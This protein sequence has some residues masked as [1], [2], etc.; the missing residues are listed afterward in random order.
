MVQETAS[1]AA[2]VPTDPVAIC[3]RRDLASTF[4]ITLC[5]KRVLELEKEGRFPRNVP[6]GG[7]AAYRVSDI[8]QWIA[9]RFAQPQQ[10]RQ[11]PPPESRT[12][13]GT[14]GANIKRRS[15]QP[16]ART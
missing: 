2:C 7:Q 14:A 6:I 11:V 4:G 15:M 3:F 16:G 8:R 5:R 10:P 13:R 9:S 1:P 12:V